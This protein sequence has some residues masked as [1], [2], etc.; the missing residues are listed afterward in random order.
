MCGY[1]ADRFQS[2]PVIANGRIVV[3]V[4]VAVLVVSFN[5]RP[6]LLTGESASMFAVTPTATVFQSTPV[7]ANGR[8]AHHLQRDR[9]HQRVSIHAR[10][11]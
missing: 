1:N 10:Y 5:P 9:V 7:I 6:L 4:A 8:I 11:C 3:A 2:T